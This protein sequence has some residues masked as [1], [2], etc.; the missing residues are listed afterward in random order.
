M[1]EVRYADPDDPMKVAP[2]QLKVIMRA[3]AEQVGVCPDCLAKFEDPLA[4]SM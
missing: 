4:W 1:I 2:A 3:Y